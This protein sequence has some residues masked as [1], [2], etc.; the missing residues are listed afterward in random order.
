MAC[1]RR[2]VDNLA[3]LLLF[4]IRQNSGNAIKNAFDIHV[5]HGVPLLY[6]HSVHWGQRHDPCI[7]EY[8]IYTSKLPDC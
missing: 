3:G 7:I 6:I 1:H 4:H 5:Y 8:N 2:S